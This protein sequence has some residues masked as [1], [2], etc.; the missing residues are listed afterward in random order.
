MDSTSVLQFK[1]EALKQVIA[2]VLQLPDDRVFFAYQP[3]KVYAEDEDE[4]EKEFFVTLNPITSVTLGTAYHFDGKKEQEVITQ[5]KE[6]TVSVNAYGTNA[7]DLL[8]KLLGVLKTSLAVQ[9]LNEAG[10]AIPR[11][12]AIRNLSGVMGAGYEERAQVDLIVSHP[13]RLTTSLMRADSV[14]ISVIKD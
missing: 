6:T 11:T 3:A 7:N 1:P 9:S 5:T 14:E 2:K 4:E 12:S 8:Q 13:Y 10:M